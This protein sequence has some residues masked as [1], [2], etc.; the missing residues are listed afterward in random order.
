MTISA[1]ET[2]TTIIVPIYNDNMIEDDENFTV[3]INSSSTPDGVSGGQVT[4]TI[5]DDDRKWFV[6]QDT[7]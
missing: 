1:G 7:Q 4:V 6:Y 3:T 5:V 2:S